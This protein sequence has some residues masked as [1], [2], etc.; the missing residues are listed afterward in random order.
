[1]QVLSGT[2]VLISL[3]TEQPLTQHSMWCVQVVLRVTVL[4]SVTLQRHYNDTAARS[5][6]YH[7]H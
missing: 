2:T 7:R 1:M 3:G 6:S 5:A 4:L